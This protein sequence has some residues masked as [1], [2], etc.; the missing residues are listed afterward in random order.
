M[1]TVGGTR[2]VPRE[3]PVHEGYPVAVPRL[4]HD[5]GTSPSVGTATEDQ[6]RC[7]PPANDSA[8][9]VTVVFVWSWSAGPRFPV[10]GDERLTDST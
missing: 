2:V 1:I 10:L 9:P 7:S 8:S 3:R 6:A 4:N 5:R